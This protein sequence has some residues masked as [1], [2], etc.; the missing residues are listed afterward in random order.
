MNSDYASLRS[1]RFTQFQ[2]AQD[3]DVILAERQRLNSKDRAFARAERVCEY[4]TGVIRHCVDESV[5]VSR[6]VMEQ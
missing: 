2:S 5:V 3:P 1:D 6:I 4:R